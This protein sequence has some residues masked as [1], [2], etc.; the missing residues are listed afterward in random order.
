MKN[1]RSFA[2]F[3]CIFVGYKYWLTAHPL[4]EELKKTISNS[5]TVQVIDESLLP[6]KNVETHVS[7]LE[8]TNVKKKE[9]DLDVGI[10]QNAITQESLNQVLAVKDDDVVLGNPDAPVKIVQYSSMTCP[11]CRYYHTAVFS[12]IKNQYID[13]GRVAYI[14]REFPFDKQAYEAAVLARCGGKEK[15]YNFLNVLFKNQDSWAYRRNYQ[16]LLTNIGQIGGVKAEDFAKCVNDPEVNNI[17]SANQRDA[18]DRLKLPWAPVIFING[19]QIDNNI[20]HNYELLSN[21]IQEYLDK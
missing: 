6:K 19:V 1:L 3:L 4:P 7:N 9:S 12:K 18:K 2:I 21:K 8:E 20:T 5:D 13:T 16:E 14:S 10:L 15:Y 17:I 11:A